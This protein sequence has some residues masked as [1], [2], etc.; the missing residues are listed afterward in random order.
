MFFM[1]SRCK[2]SDFF[3]YVNTFLFIFLIF[4]TNQVKTEKSHGI[5]PLFP[6][7]YSVQ[8]GVVPLPLFKLSHI[9]VIACCGCTIYF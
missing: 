1:Q 8:T 4:S 5:W 6:I 2:F 3:Y 9:R 7:L